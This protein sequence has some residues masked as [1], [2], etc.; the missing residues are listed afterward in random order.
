MDDWT[1]CDPDVSLG[2][3]RT[4]DGVECYALDTDGDGV[5]DHWVDVDTMWQRDQNHN[6]VF[7][8]VEHL[9]PHGFNGGGNIPIDPGDI[10]HL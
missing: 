8:D 9:L 3:L 5:A 10:D 1:P 2:D 6:F 7:D 4:I